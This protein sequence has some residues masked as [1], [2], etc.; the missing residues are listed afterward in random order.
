MLNKY[1]RIEHSEVVGESVAHQ[2]LNG[3]V[4]HRP[5]FELAPTAGADATDRLITIYLS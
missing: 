2:L 4:T 1:I 5:S 3:P